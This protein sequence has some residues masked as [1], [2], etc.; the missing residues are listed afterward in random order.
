MRRVVFCRDLLEESRIYDF[1]YAKR[2]TLRKRA[3]KFSKYMIANDL[4]L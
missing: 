4:H 1:G 2:K 3:Y